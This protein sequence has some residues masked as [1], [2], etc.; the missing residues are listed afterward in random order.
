[1]VTKFSA[2]S[3][4]HV[5]EQV[6]VASSVQQNSWVLDQLEGGNALNMLSTSVEVRAILSAELLQHCLDQLAQRHE[7]LRTTLQLLDGQLMQVVAADL[8]VPVVVHNLQTLPAEALQIQ[9]RFLTSQRAQSPFKL[10]QGPLFR[11]SLLRLPGER[12]LLVLSAHRAICD[13]WSLAQLTRELAALITASQ[14]G[15]PSP[16][17]PA[18]PY[19]QVVQHQALSQSERAAELDYWKQHVAGA[20]T[21]LPLPFDYARPAVADVQAG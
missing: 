15:Q 1:M 18:V 4:L 14:Q 8:Q 2:K 21:T 3:S 19:A 12:S 7:L 11:C 16:S 6:F 5:K 10:E 13:A 17:S 9:I 20:P